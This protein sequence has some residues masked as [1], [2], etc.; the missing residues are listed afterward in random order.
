MMYEIQSTSEFRKG[1]KSAKKR[2]RN[3]DALAKVIDTLAEGRQLP[4]SNRDH[5][6]IGNFRGCRECH[7]EPDWLLVYR[8]DKGKLVLM[9]V[10]TGTH[11]DL[12]KK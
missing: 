4:D 12:F 6:L 9:L 1:Y 3:M 2:G 11:S 8:I 5:Q 7:V 10:A